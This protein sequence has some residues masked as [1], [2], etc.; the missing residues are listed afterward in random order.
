VDVDELADAAFRSVAT[1]GGVKPLLNTC[2][3]NSPLESTVALT[4]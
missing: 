1:T 3:D 4:N 2:F